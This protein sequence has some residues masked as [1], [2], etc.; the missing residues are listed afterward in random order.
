MF[1]LASLEAGEEGDAH[2]IQAEFLVVDQC[3]GEVLLALRSA[4]ETTEGVLS[5]APDLSTA[6]VSFS[7]AVLPSEGV[8]NTFTVE[9]QLTFDVQAFGESSESVLRFPLQEDPA[10]FEP[11]PGT[12]W[13]IFRELQAGGNR[14][15]ELTRVVGCQC[16]SMSPRK[17][18]TAIEA[19]VRALRHLVSQRLRGHLGG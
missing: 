15:G 17:S 11:L 9:Q 5:L 12:D 7:G 14:L 8:T 10:T 6:S 18:E 4:G 19:T 1:K 13:I 3:T 2:F 16:T